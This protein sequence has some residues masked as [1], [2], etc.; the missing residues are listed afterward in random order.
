MTDFDRSAIAGV[1]VTEVNAGGCSVKAR[2]RHD[3]LGQVEEGR[4]AEDVHGQLFVERQHVA[5]LQMDRPLAALEI[6]GR[7]GDRCGGG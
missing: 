6:V 5:E 3:V 4:S 1:A 7:H 2:S